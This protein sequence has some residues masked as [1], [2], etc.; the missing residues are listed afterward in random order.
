MF[1]V[2]V[3][4]AM[5]PVS[6]VMFPSQFGSDYTGINLAGALGSAIGMIL[7]VTGIVALATRDRIHR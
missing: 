4:I 6:C 5:V 1:L 7:M 2:L 3:G